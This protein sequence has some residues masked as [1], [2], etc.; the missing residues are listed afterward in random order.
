MSTQKAGRY[1]HG[2]LRRALLDAALQLAG[3]RG[4]NGFTLREV[5]RQ[6]GVSHN[7]PYHHFPDKAALVAAMAA[8]YFE[9]LAQTL[10]T[11]VDQ[12]AGSARDK[13][14]ASAVAYVRFA[15][16]H[17][18]AFRLMYRPELRQSTAAT[19]TDAPEA[20]LAACASRAYQVLIDSVAACQATGF[21]PPGDLEARALTAWA[22][23]HGLAV[24]LVDGVPTAMIHVADDGGVE[25]VTAL[26][27]H[28]LMHGLAGSA[29]VL[30][31]SH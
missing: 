10:Q 14:L 30:P 9:A 7:A 5:A 16:D 28:S 27:T 20:M 15:L 11:A 3:E 2:D 19:P 21:M 18:D 23:V 12:T 22:T 1:H 4:I 6:A 25:R 31:S 24:L 29:L 26:V 8:E 13:F 17:T